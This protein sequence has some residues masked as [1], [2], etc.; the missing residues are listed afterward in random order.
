M[1]LLSARGS[2]SGTIFTELNLSRGLIR[3]ATKELRHSRVSE[4][5]LASVIWAAR[6]KYVQG[7]TLL[8]TEC[9]YC[10][11]IGSFLHLLSCVSMGRLPKTDEELVAF[12]AE[13][14]DRAYNANKASPD[15]SWRVAD[16]S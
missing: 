12:L 11:Q 13:L 6:F 10:G 15:P 1:R 3:E 8:P 4:A 2:L 16:I 9:T 14:A 7:N 5:T